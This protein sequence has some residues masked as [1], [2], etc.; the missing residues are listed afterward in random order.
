MKFMNWLGRVIIGCV[1]IVSAWGAWYVVYQQSLAAVQEEEKPKPK[2]QLAVE[3]VASRLDKIDEKLSFVG[4]LLPRAQT[5]VRSKLSGYIQDLP[6][7]VGD[8]VEKGEVICRLDETDFSKEIEQARA[9]LKVAKAQLEVRIEESRLAKSNADLEARLA[10]NNAGTSQQAETA[11]AN[12]QIALANEE[13]DRARVIEAE[14][15]VN[16]IQKGFKDLVL[17]APITGYVA[18]RIA[19]IGDLA[20]PDVPLL[21]IVDLDVVQTTVQV[22]EKDYN[23][24]SVGHQATV[25]V[26][27]YPD[28]Q[29]RGVVTRIAPVLD[30]ASRTAE[31]HIDV[32]NEDLFLK[33]G[34]YGRVTLNPETQ[35]TGVVIPLAAVVNA[36]NRSL[37]YVVDQQTSKVEQ[38]A[39]EL[40]LSDGIIVE[41][42]TGVSPDEIIVTLGNRL[43]QP[44][45]EVEVTV[46]PWPTAG[47]IAEE[48][49]LKP[50]VDVS[51][52]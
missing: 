17:T 26:D 47:S 33:P 28:L 4:T 51:G 10:Q 48:R 15:R 31:A 34:M 24:V 50:A 49:D 12:Y 45:Q 23:R 2:K 41:I 36:G 39:V 44:N 1:A 46:V 13:L 20:K 19:D 8:R 21:L 52:E 11:T 16:A 35:R 30:P 25:S 42:R 32:K 14:E 43:V 6:F 5:E 3:A 40:G 38:R 22:I 29:F 7:N 9:A 18:E 27:A 37:V